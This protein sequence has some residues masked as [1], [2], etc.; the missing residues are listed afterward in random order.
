MREVVTQDPGAYLALVNYLLS[1]DIHERIEWSAPPDEP[2]L[3]VLDDP[4]RVHVE[5]WSSLM[6]RIVDVPE[7]LRARGCSPQAAGR[8]F[9]LAVRDSVAPW[10]EGTWRVEAEGGCLSVEADG[11]RADLDTDVTVLAAVFNGYLSP[12]EAARAGL[13]EVRE[14]PALDDA[15]AVFSVGRPPFC[16]DWF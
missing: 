2:L 15:A 3:S 13:L 7:A 16:M 8:R 9:T 12:V 5:A 4:H 10:N 14:R 11:G 6:L 1:H